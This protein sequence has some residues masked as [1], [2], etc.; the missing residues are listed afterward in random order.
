[1]NL[2]LTL[3][4]IVNCIEAINSGRIAR[5]KM[6][7]ED[8]FRNHTHSNLGQIHVLNAKINTEA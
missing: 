2:S 5:G 4:F 3:S 1:M 8:G 6:E 7:E